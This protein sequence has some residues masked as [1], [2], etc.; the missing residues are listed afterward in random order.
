MPRAKSPTP[1][2]R[3]AGDG[4]L[5]QRADG[6]WCGVVDI[7]TEDGTRKQK[8]VY[9][10]S[11]ATAR[12]KLDELKD[13][14]AKGVIPSTTM[15][16][17]KWLPY[18]LD[19]I[20]R[21]HIRPKTYKYYE[22]SVRLHLVP[23]IGKKR[24]DRLTPADVRAMLAGLDSSSN[25]RRA[26]GTLNLALKAAMVDGLLA[27]N[28]VGAVRKPKHTPASREAFTTD[29]CKAIIRTAIEIEAGGGPAL[30]TRWA[31][32]FLTAG[33]QAELTGLEWDRV[34]LDAGIVDLSWQLQQLTRVHGCG[35]QVD[36]VW[37]CEVNR[38][39]R[40]R[41]AYCPQARWDF[42]DGFEYRECYRSLVWTRPKTA[43]GTRVVPLVPAMAELLRAH[44]QTGGPNPHGL[45]WHHP[46]GR[47]LSPTDDHKAW[48]ALLRAARITVAGQTLP[49]HAARHSAA[50]MLLEAGVPE[51]VRMRVMG[52]SSVAAHRGY[53]HVDQAHARAA[54]DNLAALLP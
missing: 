22:E 42:E 6:M 25:R 29:Q 10:K 7:P 4:G 19:E 9:S 48:Q 14:I 21:P 30:A 36:E 1:K 2:R 15:T 47:P 53:L 34:D 17:G 26:H 52:Q 28:V 16:V 24:L 41:A 43:A 45:V 5:F 13:N 46:D 35:A 49:L 3:A 44:S 39:P 50:T 18:W 38:G 12:D 33:R 20:H 54:L 8:R 27:R 40:T 23:A 37:P 51:E 31:A 11:Y 32:A